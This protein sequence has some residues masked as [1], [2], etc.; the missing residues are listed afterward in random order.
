MCVFIC[1][2]VPY[3]AG[4]GS[5]VLQCL[6]HRRHRL[7]H[8]HT[9]LIMPALPHPLHVPSHHVPPHRGLPR[10]TLPLPPRLRT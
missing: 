4:R 1:L 10:P 2:R 5:P 8:T 3:A 7:T 6:G 9:R